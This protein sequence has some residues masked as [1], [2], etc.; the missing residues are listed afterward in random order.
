MARIG[1]IGLGIMGAPMAR[2]LARA[3]HDLTVCDSDPA[4][5]AQFR[6][7]GMTV[8]RTA[9]GCA[10]QDVILILVPAESH[11]RDVLTGPDGLLDALDPA[12]PPV[13]VVMSTIP[14]DAARECAALLATRR[15]GMLDA[16]ISGGVDGAEAGTL[17][18][19]VGG[20]E[21]DLARVRPVL[22]SVGRSIPY[23]G[24]SG[25]GAATKVINNIVGV[26][27]WLLMAE[28]MALAKSLGMDLDRVVQVME[29]STG[30]NM[31]TKLWPARR[32]SYRTY[33]ANPA[34]VAANH[35]ICGKDLALAMDLAERL[36]LR[37]P[38]AA[39]VAR[40][41]ADVTPDALRQL[42]GKIG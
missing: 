23:C 7:A 41:V 22:A 29:E 33:A 42:W 26:T 36:G 4:V 12:A 34:M 25:A 8:V 35:R 17:T 30:R 3:G 14:P 27:N 19:M 1:V 13:V 5:A 11:V 20:N 24:P 38:I 32:A 39:G 28:A 37:L 15:A 18:I 10:R 6:Q 9:A 16:P 2:R 40:S 31:G 21:A